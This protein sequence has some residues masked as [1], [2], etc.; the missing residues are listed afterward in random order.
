M[1]GRSGRIVAAALFVAGTVV[2]PAAAT[3]RDRCIPFTAGVIDAAAAPVAQLTH[4]ATKDTPMTIYYEHKTSTPAAEEKIYFNVQSYL[5]ATTTIRGR[6]EF[7]KQSDVNMF[8]YDEKGNQIAAADGVNYVPLHVGPLDFENG[9]RATVG[10][11]QLP[12]IKARP[13]AGF[14]LES[15]AFFSTGTGVKLQLWSV[16]GRTR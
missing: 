11:E 3:A 4:H 7:D 1:T 16:G 2:M 12:G 10:E 9:G 5:P 6:L 14:T 8:V 13:C 15:R